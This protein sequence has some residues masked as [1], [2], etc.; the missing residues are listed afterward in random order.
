MAFSISDVCSDTIHLHCLIMLF[1]FFFLMIL[2]PPSSTRT[3]TLFPYTTLF[4]SRALFALAL[5]LGLGLLAAGVAALAGEPR[6][7]LKLEAGRGMPAGHD[8]LWWALAAM[9]AALAGA[10][11]WLQPRRAV[12][13]TA[14]MT[15]VL[16]CG[17]GLAIAPQ[18]DGESSSRDLMREAR[19]RKST[20]LN[21]SH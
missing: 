10:A 6:F 9:G 1:L 18:L 17:W 19:D 3:Y 13:V 11:L 7:E 20:R 12:A 15:A 8:G 14:V 4:R 21:S 16:W 2:R 5:L